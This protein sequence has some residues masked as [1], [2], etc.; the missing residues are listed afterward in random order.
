MRSI[1]D[2]LH[3]KFQTKGAICGDKF[4]YL[5]LCVTRDREQKQIRI[6]Q[7]GYLQKVLEKFEMHTY[8]GRVMPLE[9][10]PVPHGK[11]RRPWIKICTI[12]QWDASYM[13]LL[14]AALTSHTLL[15]FLL[16]PK[17]LKYVAKLEGST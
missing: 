8:K 13:Q 1:V 2:T 17:Y 6:D 3:E 11:N 5:G 16:H 10:K 14:E 9:P 12:K 7:R 4:S 15:V